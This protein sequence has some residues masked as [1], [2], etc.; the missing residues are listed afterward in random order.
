[1]I[2]LTSSRNSCIY[3]ARLLSLSREQG[4]KADEGCKMRGEFWGKITENPY[5]YEAELLVE[6]RQ[7][8]KNKNPPS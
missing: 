7:E 6:V 2:F 1:M 3:H 4:G 8:E 5:L